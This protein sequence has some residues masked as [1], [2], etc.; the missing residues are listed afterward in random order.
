MKLRDTEIWQQAVKI[1]KERL[2]LPSE[3]FELI[4]GELAVEAQKTYLMLLTKNAKN[5]VGKYK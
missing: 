3:S 2:G 4:K 1:T 5:N